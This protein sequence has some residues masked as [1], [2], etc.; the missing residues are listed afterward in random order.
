MKIPIDI[1]TDL[2][3]E[4]QGLSHGIVTLQLHYRDSHLHHYKINREKS[5]SVA[6]PTKAEGDPC[7]TRN[8]SIPGSFISEVYKKLY[9]PNK[10]NN[11]FNNLYTTKR[12]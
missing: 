11:V 1:I 8:Y 5:Q 7:N 2:E 3:N 9:K 10:T 6:T 12:T 4:A